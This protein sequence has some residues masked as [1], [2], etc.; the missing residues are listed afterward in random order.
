MLN[1]L[2]ERFWNHRALVK[3]VG[4]VSASR[5][6]RQAVLMIAV[7]MA[8]RVLGK[9]LLGIWALIYIVIQFGV[10]ISDSGISTFV[11]RQ[12]D[13]TDR[14]YSTALLLSTALAGLIAALITSL[15]FPLSSLF[16]LEDYAWHFVAAGF[17]V[18]PLTVNGILQAKLRRDRRFGAM[19]ASD[20][21]ASM[22]M[23]VG[24]GWMLWSGSGLWAFIIPTI[25]AAVVGLSICVAVSG[26]PRLTMDRSC[27]KEIVDYSLGIVGFSSLNHWA[28]NMDHIL[29]GKFLGAAPLGV[30]SLAYRIMMLPLSQINATAQTVAL[31]YL[32]PHQ[33]DPAKL[34]KSM[35][36]IMVIVG[37]LTTLPTIWVWLE[38]ELLVSVMLGDGWGEVADLLVVFAPLA[39]LQAL[40]NPIGM[41]FLVTGKTKRLFLIGTV[42]TAATVVSFVA[43]VWMGT[44]DS[45]VICYAIA[46][47]CMV[48]IMVGSGMRTIGGTLRQWVSW[49]V[50]FFVCLPICWAAQRITPVAGSAWLEAGKTLVLTTVVCSFAYLYA[51]RT[52]F[53]VAMMPARVRSKLSP[54][55]S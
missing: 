43:G 12:R 6:I 4:A 42:H 35:R 47:L 8:A 54:R 14:M 39:V 10:L 36:S 52:T 19:F 20:V 16:G 21:G 38:R 30:Y 44:L 33:D 18:I 45:V 31:P 9:E 26:L 48:P 24:A 2:K 13:L 41:C 3:D 27:V 7:A 25:V 53:A 40:V 50:P 15:G 34:R 1:H 23:L 29:I 17:T 51:Y 32:S 46:N 22:T 37:M 55:T 28:R 49:C 11:V 5:L